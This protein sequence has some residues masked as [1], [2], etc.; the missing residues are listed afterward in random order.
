MGCSECQQGNHEKCVE[1]NKEKTTGCPGNCQ[2][3]GTPSARKV[4][5]GGARH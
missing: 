1:L 3:R 4:G 2:H 5:Q